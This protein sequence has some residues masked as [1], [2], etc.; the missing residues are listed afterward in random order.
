M[1]KKIPS[2]VVMEVAIQENNNDNVVSVNANRV[3]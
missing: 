3:I 2:S 1:P